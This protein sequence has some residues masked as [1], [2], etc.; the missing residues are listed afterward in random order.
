MV[1][2]RLFAVVNGLIR[3]SRCQCEELFAY[4]RSRR[5]QQSIVDYNNDETEH[6]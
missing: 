5:D 2:R 6:C 3:H 4:L 1:V